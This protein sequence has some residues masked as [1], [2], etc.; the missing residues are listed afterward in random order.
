MGVSKSGLDL[1]KAFKLSL[2]FAVPPVW[3][4]LSHSRVG[5]SQLKAAQREQLPALKQV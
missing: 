3:V 4:M 5:R 2:L 1:V